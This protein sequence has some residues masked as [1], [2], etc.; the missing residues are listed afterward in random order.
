MSSSVNRPFDL[1]KKGKILK[2]AYDLAF[3]VQAFVHVATLGFL[4]LQPNASAPSVMLGSLGVLQPHGVQSFA[5]GLV[6]QLYSVWEMRQ[7]GFVTTLDAAKAV[8]G[9]VAG[10]FLVGSGA[11]WARLWSWRETVLNDLSTLP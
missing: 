4:A 5:A 1:S 6:Y 10:Q 9:V 8:L 2:S 11:T 7:N 3:A